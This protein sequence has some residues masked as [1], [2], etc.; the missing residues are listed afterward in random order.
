MK[1]SIKWLFVKLYNV[2]MLF[3]AIIVLSFNA[4][5]KANFYLGLIL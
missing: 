1:Y 5:T 2:P 4:L 3:K